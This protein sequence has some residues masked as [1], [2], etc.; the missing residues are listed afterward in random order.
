MAEDCTGSRSGIRGAALREARDRRGTSF[1]PGKN[2]GAYGDAGGR[3]TNDAD[4]A[5]QARLMINHGSEVRY[6]HQIQGFNTAGIRCR[7]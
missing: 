1:Y 3:P 5:R 7:Q 4:L 2:L 6:V